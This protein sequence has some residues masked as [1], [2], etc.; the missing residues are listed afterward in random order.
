MPQNDQP[1]KKTKT[2]T[3]VFRVD[4]DAYSELENRAAL[5]GKPVNDWCRDETLARLAEASSLTANEQLIHAEV[6]LFGS[7]MSHYFD[8]IATKKLTP[9]V[10]DQLKAWL[11]RERKEVYQEYFSKRKEGK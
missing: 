11:M 4:E 7:V 1:A 2:R 6:I 10:N 8:L 9:E 5:A 3:I